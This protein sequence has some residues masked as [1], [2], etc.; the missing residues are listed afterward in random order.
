MSWYSKTQQYDISN[1]K[2]DVPSEPST[3]ASSDS[4]REK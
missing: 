1:S 4:G 3:T 2:I